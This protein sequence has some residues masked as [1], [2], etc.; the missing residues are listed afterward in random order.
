M[1]IVMMPWP[2]QSNRNAMRCGAERSAVEPSRT[3]R[4]HAHTMQYD[5]ERWTVLAKTIFA[6]VKNAF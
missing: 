2:M 6:F 3:K 4:A 1:L 5:A